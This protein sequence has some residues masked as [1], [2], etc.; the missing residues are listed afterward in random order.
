MREVLRDDFDVAL[1]WVGGVEQIPGN[2]K[3]LRAPFE[4]FANGAEKSHPEIG[5]PRRGFAGREV[6]EVIAEM[7]ITAMGESK[8]HIVSQ[9]RNIGDCGMYALRLAKAGEKKALFHIVL[10]VRAARDDDAG[11]ETYI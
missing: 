5:L 8:G 3:G 2:K 10:T 1:T 9:G 6:A 11:S 7:E 4:C